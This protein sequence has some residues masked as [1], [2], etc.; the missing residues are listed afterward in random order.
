MLRIYNVHLFTVYY[1]YYRLI[2]IKQTK[3][4]LSGLSMNWSSYDHCRNLQTS[5]RLEKFVPLF[6]CYTKHLYKLSFFV[7]LGNFSYEDFTRLLKLSDVI[8]IEQW[9]FFSVSHLLWQL[10]GPVTL[11]LDSN[12]LLALHVTTIWQICLV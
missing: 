8:A 2:S 11:S 12:R 7:H 4:S 1:R 6:S 3:K 5:C 10:R 9:G